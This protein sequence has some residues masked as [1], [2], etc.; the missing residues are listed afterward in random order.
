MVERRKEKRLQAS[1]ALEISELFKQDNVKVKNLNAPIEV[2]DISKS[3][4][5]IKSKCILPIGY[6]FNA[7]ITL[8]DETSNLFL[9]IQIIRNNDNGDGTYDYGCEFVGMAPVLHYIFDDYEEKLKEK[10]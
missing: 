7:K 5:R 1:I 6:Y 9:V 4:I 3:G 2:I 8:G 10:E